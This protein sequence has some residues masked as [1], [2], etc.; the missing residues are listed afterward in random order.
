VHEFKPDFREDA[1]FR[2]PDIVEEVTKTNGTIKSLAAVLKSPTIAGTI[3]VSSTTPIATMV[4]VF[5][6]T[7]YIFAVA[8]HN[9]PSR[10]RITVG[11]SRDTNARV[12][13]EA[14]SVSI[15]QGSFEDQF[16]GYGVHLYQ[17]P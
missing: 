9:S 4:K 2:Y 12:I 8:M 17:I 13:G 6:N 15:V 14:R 7:T 3:A 16:E 10:V 5:E 1:I 11:D